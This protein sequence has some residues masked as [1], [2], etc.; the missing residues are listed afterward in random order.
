VKTNI[1][2][3][4]ISGTGMDS[5]Q[6][7]KRLRQEGVI[8]GTVNNSTLR[9]L[10]HRNVTREECE[11]AAYIVARVCKNVAKTSGQRLSFS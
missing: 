1:V 8:G 6:M 11:C 5:P 7:L 9:F 4:D 2:A 10:T 3:V